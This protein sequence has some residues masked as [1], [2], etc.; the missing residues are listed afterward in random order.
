MGERERF[1]SLPLAHNEDADFIEQPHGEGDEGEGEDVGGGGDDS[2]YDEQG[3]NDMAAV[4]AHHRCVDEPHA[5]KEPTDDGDFEQDAHGEADAHQGV[6]VGVDGNGVGHC[7]AYL[8]GAEEM[9]Y[10]G[11]DE[12]ITEQYPEQEHGVAGCHQ[13]DGVVPFMGVEGGGDEMEK[14]VDEIGGGEQHSGTERGFDVE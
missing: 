5:A 6:H 4:V 10:Q 8:I 12:E 1:S 9:E 11:E 13:A 3:H 2:C 14:Q 7:F